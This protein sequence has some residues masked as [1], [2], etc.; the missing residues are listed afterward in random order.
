MKLL[1]SLYYNIVLDTTIRYYVSIYNQIFVIY[2]L[3]KLQLKRFV[4]QYF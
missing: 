2:F 3:V 1:V 4:K